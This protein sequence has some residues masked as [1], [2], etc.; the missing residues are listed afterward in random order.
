[1]TADALVIIDSQNDFCDKKGSL[2]V[3]GAEEDIARLSDYIKRENINGIF[4]SLDSHDV[5]AVFHPAF[6]INDAGEH[7]ASFTCIT[8]DAF[9]S[10]E[11]KVVAGKN[12]PFA[13]RT[14]RA[15][16]AKSIPGVTIW[17]EHCVVSTWGHQIAAPLLDAIAHWREKTGLS[18]RYIFKGENPYTDQFSIFEGVDDSYPETS[19]NNALFN[20]LS[21]FDTVTF[22]GEALSHC[23][24][25]SVLSYMRRLCVPQTVRLLTD[26]ASPVSG[27]DKKESLDR[28]GQCGVEFITSAAPRPFL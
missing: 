10:G 14:F 25:E 16:R 15:M 24:Q 21:S 26:C 12:M 18:V 23:V 5:A 27:F 3:E 6:W 20:R 22:A 17:P 4:A 2:Y 13:L 28:L 1:M 7:P 19:F 11:W 9:E 8:H